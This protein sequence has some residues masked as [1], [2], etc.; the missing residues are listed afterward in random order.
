M[1][2]LFQPC[3]VACATILAAYSCIASPSSTASG[4]RLLVSAVRRVAIVCRF[5][6]C[7]SGGFERGALVGRSVFAESGK[8][9]G[10]CVYNASLCVQRETN[11]WAWRSK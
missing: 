10:R 9:P 6:H 5:L 3:F 8:S 1:P 2:C 7:R 11:L 4:L